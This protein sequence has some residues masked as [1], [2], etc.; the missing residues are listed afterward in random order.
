[1]HTRG[2]LGRASQISLRR[3]LNRKRKEK[4]RKE[5]KRK[6]RKRKGKIKD[7]RKGLAVNSRM[8]VPRTCAFA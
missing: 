4:K 1:M 8:E 5:K 3:I 7:P 2:V 6:E